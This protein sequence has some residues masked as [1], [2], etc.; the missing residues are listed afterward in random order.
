MSLKRAALHLQHGHTALE[1]HGASETD[2]HSNLNI[3][4]LSHLTQWHILRAR[5]ERKVL[6]LHTADCR[7]AKTHTQKKKKT[8]R[9][10]G[11]SRRWRRKLF[12]DFVAARFIAAYFIYFFF[13]SSLERWCMTQ[14]CDGGVHQSSQNVIDYSEFVAIHRGRIEK[15]PRLRRNFHLCIY[16]S[17]LTSGSIS[18]TPVTVK[19]PSSKHARTHS[20]DNFDPR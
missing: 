11:I 7:D 13:F 3:I 4:T 20:A 16:Q 1:Q 10:G 8:H 17:H 19:T 12:V 14:M 18:A 9:N 15:K 5:D 6:G 2:C